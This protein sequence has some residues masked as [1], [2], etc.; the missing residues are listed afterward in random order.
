MHA[1][2]GIGAIGRLRKQPG[3]Y[4]AGAQDYRHQQPDTKNRPHVH[5]SWAS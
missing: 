2:A 4:E 1:S 3:I 5:Q